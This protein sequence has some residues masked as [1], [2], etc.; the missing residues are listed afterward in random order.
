MAGVTLNCG[1]RRAVLERLHAVCEAGDEAVLAVVMATLGSTYRKPGALAL[2]E[3]D[4]T[5]TGV[6]SGGCLE[7]VWAA[8]A[9]CALH[10]GLP[11]WQVF[12]T[13]ADS[14]LWFGSGSACRGQTQVLLWPLRGVRDAV[15][16]A[17]WRALNHLAAAQTLVADPE[18][19]TPTPRWLDGGQ[20][21]QG[22]SCRLA[23]AP[24]V[25]IVG[26]SAE[27][28]P[29]AALLRASGWWVCLSEHR[30]LERTQP[31]AEV[32]QWIAGRPKWAA[33]A[34]PG[35]PPVVLIMNH[36]A[37]A[38]LEALRWAALQPAVRQIGLLGPTERRDVLLQALT[39]SERDA[40][41]ARL[42]APAGLRLGGHGP[43]A[44]ALAI[45][46]WLQQ[47]YPQP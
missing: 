24:W 6:L 21:A 36:Q 12:D 30:Q 27:A 26:A 2:L 39:T 7:S 5:R 35:V 47:A 8:R 19:S 38:D 13:R 20:A 10:G 15:D 37:D 17:R 4:G 42:C 28:V 1:S 40:L 23:P 34:L 43:M 29:L 3:A 45:A 41:Q 11:C 18:A 9:H 14:D 46:A 44:V 16:L 33:A 31:G 25:W 32:D 22:L